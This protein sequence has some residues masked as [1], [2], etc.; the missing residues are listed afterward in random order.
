MT[1]AEAVAL[2]AKQLDGHPVDEAA[3][4]E[5][6]SIIRVTPS[7]V[8]KLPR[9]RERRKPAYGG[10]LAAAAP[11]PADPWPLLTPET[12]AQVLD[13]SRN[14]WPLLGRDE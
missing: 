7:P 5:A 11:A 14:A 3:L 12:E 8:V 6:I 2:R 4:A 13:A 1:Y 9:P 10:P